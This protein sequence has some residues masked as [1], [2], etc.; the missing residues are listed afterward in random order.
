MS[1]TAQ[2]TSSSCNQLRSGYVCGDTSSDVSSDV[3]QHAQALR[4]ANWF[5]E[6]HQITAGSFK[7]TLRQAHWNCMQVIR[8]TTSQAVL[9]IGHCRPDTFCI[10]MPIAASGVIRWRGM[11]V[12][13]SD[14]VCFS[15][16]HELDL[17][18]PTECDLMVVAVDLGEFST[19]AEDVGSYKLNG[20]SDGAS[21]IV[22]SHASHA[23]LSNALN[24]A[25]EMTTVN[26]FLLS[27]TQ[28]AKTLQMS[29]YDQML[30]VLT[31]DVPR[32]KLNS[33]RNRDVLVARAR[34][35]LHEHSGDVVS[36]AEVCR[37]LRVSRRTLQY[38][39]QDV[40]GVNPIAYLRALRLNMVRRE[41]KTCGKSG[42]VLDIAARWGFWHP[43]HFSN[44]Y[45]VMFGEL[46]SET[47]QRYA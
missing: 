38:A 2:D 40:V 34:E 23:A 13:L 20:S 4:R 15:G 45:R 16:A 29:I 33:S 41:L 1:D 37:A 26:P 6:Y 24:A 28:S 47:R 30:D 42:A 19:Y 44:D 46:P 17:L 11:H 18:T 35:Y 39:F 43:S 32:Q 12:G 22:N 7:G 10:G 3:D 36:I 8:E 9:Q 25:L 27:R 21:L 5:E 31:A 14:I